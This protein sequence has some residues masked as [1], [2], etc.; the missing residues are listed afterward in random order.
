[1]FYSCRFVSLLT[2]LLKEDAGQNLHV[3]KGMRDVLKLASV[4]VAQ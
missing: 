4:I 2:L 1:M 3:F